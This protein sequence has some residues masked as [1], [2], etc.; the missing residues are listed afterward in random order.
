MLALDD[1]VLEN[2][3][4]AAQVGELVLDL[5]QPVGR[6]VADRSAVGAVLEVEQLGNIVERE[7]EFLR[8][9]DEADALGRGGSP[10]KSPLRAD[11]G[12]RPRSR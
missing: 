6:D 1:Q 4:H 3:L 11:T 7:A 12:S 8:A 10:R 5:R 2:P 9:L